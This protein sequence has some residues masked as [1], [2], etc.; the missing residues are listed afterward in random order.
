MDHQA[1]KAAEEVRR[2]RIFLFGIFYSASPV[3]VFFEKV[4]LIADQ[5]KNRARSDN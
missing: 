4:C 2:N 3:A 1:P 5:C